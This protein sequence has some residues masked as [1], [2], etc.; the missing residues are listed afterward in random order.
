MSGRMKILI[1]GANGYLGAR[2]YVDLKKE[3]FEI[4]GTYHSKQLF[5]DLIKV[6]ITKENEVLFTVSQTKPDIILHVV[7]KASPTWCEEHPREAELINVEGTRNVV[8]AA[9]KQGC[10]VILISSVMAISPKTFYGETKKEE[11]GIVMATKAGFLILRPALIMGF[12]PNTTND[13][14]FNRLL[15]NIAGTPAIYDT[16]WKSQI[17]WAGHISELVTIAVKKGLYGEVIPVMC[18]ETKSRFDVANDVLSKFGIKVQPKDDKDTDGDLMDEKE[19]I[20]LKLPRHSYPEIIE[21]LVWEI[22]NK[23]KFAI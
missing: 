4:K 13:R 18:P 23:D 1:T 9:N 11:E 12:S 2:L 17:T 8:S 22:K 21:K 15:N 16:S 7:A 5:P 3:G 20:R 14:P 19:L 6:D 10:K